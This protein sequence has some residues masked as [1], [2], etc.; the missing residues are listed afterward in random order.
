MSMGFAAPLHE[1]AD[2]QGYTVSGRFE[3]RLTIMLSFD[4]NGAKC[5]SVDGCD[6]PEAAVLHVSW[7]TPS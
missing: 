7:K 1:S 4:V 3:S 2:F 5:H 6:S